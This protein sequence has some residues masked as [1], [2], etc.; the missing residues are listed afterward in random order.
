MCD[1]P[2]N[3]EDAAIRVTYGC[4]RTGTQPRGSGCFTGRDGQASGTAAAVADGRDLRR[5]VIGWP[6]ADPECGASVNRADGTECSGA[7]ALA[8]TTGLQNY[9]SPCHRS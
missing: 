2:D 8:G 7:C 5:R 9:C 3:A 6:L 1:V 4:R